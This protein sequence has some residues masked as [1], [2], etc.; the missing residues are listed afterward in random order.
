MLMY[1]NLDPVDVAIMRHT[2]PITPQETFQSDRE[3]YR[4]SLDRADV[5]GTCP[6]CNAQGCPTC[7]GT[8]LVP[9]DLEEARAR[10]L[11]AAAAKISA[12]LTEHHL[13]W[14]HDWPVINNA[15]RSVQSSCFDLRSAA[16]QT[17]EIAKRRR[18]EDA[19]EQARR[20]A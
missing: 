19:M 3:D 10:D 15:L 18:T 7:Y 5:A 1:R 12:L 20:R 8:G 4:A 14:D 2:R 9:L 17:R 16:R 13:T 11:E 6:E